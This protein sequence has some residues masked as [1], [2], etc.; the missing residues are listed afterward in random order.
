MFDVALFG[1]CYFGSI[2]DLLLLESLILGDASV[3][4][5]PV[6]LVLRTVAAGNESGLSQVSVAPH[7]PALLAFA[8]R[9]SAYL[10]NFEIAHI[11][12]EDFEIRHIACEAEI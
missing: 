7:F 4:F 8:N 1:H 3:L 6:L 2:S 12:S 9:A 10:E 5:W 11:A